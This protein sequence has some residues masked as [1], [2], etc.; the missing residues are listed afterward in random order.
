MGEVVGL[1]VG[2]LDGAIVGVMVGLIVG[3]RVAAAA[4]A[5]TGSGAMGAAELPISRVG[6]WVMAG[7]DPCVGPAVPASVGV[8]VGRLV[9]GVTVGDGATGAFKLEGSRI[10]R[11]SR[12][13]DLAFCCSN[14]VSA[15]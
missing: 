1:L 11:F 5:M 14:S 12:K 13:S 15:A 9:A 10:T 7:I 3:K 6:V 4:T 2:R 8:W